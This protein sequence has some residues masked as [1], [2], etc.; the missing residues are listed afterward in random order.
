M[1]VTPVIPRPQPPGRVLGIEV[2]RLD[3]VEPGGLGR[4]DIVAVSGWYV[5]TA[6]DNCPPIAAIYRDGALPY[7]RGDADELA[8]CERSG[9]LY[10]TQ[11]DRDGRLQHAG[12]SA[13]PVSMV[14]GVIAPL[15]LERIGSDMTEV[16]IIGRFV[17]SGDGCGTSAGCRR[18][19]VIDHVAWT[20]GA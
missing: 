4:N 16:V 18:E 1:A 20:P 8:F 11:P 17:P 5:P 2:R 14:I 12:L 9:V 15:E 19:L 10:A 13:V 7:V 6:I 3:D